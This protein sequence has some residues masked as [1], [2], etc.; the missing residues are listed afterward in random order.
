MRL[1]A[2]A[3]LGST[4][5][6]AAQSAPAQQRARPQVHIVATGGTIASTNYYN[7]KEPSVG[8]DQLLRAVPALDT[9]AT[10]SAQ[11]FSNVGSSSVTMAM[12]LGLSRT[13]TDTL[14]ARRAL[15]GIVVTHGTDTM[16]ETAY[17]LDLTVADPRP[18]VLT[19][20]M[21][22]ADGVGIDGPA[23]LLNAMR[24][25]V[26]PAARGR[27]T[28]VSMN[29]EIF[30]ARDVTK[31]NTARPNAFVAPYRGDVGIADPER[32]VF[33]RAAER[34]PTFDLGTVRDLPRVDIIYS[35][36]GADGTLIAA[37]V[38]AGARG[39]VIAATGRGGIPPMQRA[40]IDSARAKG[41]VVIVSSRTGSGSVSVG[42]GV[43]KRQADRDAATIGSGDL[44]PQKARVLLM[45]ALTRTS[46]VAEIAR[47][48][49]L[50]Q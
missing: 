36:A 15:A 6:L 11:Q 28:M 27:G 48:F 33:H 49:L 3:F 24:I 30:A 18:I 29:D 9:V 35:H 47:I 19:G 4:T 23:N 1:F 46:D 14:R 41:V 17:F 26:S 45:L 16:E 32:V 2:L 25:A 40:V 7:A 44:N 39:V 12:W 21:R 20:A 13:I 8:V 10:I 31:A 43:T 34:R 50:H 42:D 38:S 37:A 5:Y 22:P